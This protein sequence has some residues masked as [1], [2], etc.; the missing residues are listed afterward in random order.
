MTRI[1]VVGAINEDWVASV[2]HRPGPG[3]TV[4]TD[5]FSLSPGGKGANQA[6]AAARAGASVAMIGA[7]GDDDSGRRQLQAL[8]AYGV[9]VR[10]VQKIIGVTTGTAF[11]TVTGDGENSIVVGLG[12]NGFL[13]P[14]VPSGLP[15]P[16]VVLAQTEVG[17]DVVN[18]AAT[19]A[20]EV[21]ARLVVN[22]G[23]VVPLSPATLRSA[24]PIVVN[25]HEAA[26]IL[27][28]PADPAEIAARIRKHTSA[29]SAV[30]TL[31]AD[32]A[33]FSDASG[34]T[35][36][37]GVQA[38]QVVDTTGA[39]D[40]FVGVLGARLAA[41]DGVRVAVRAAVAAA[42]ESVSWRGARPPRD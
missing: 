25:A 3:Q 14:G 34:E 8:S 17:P 35:A 31:G 42:A 11:I 29:R 27:G 18:A 21:G 13:A 19:Y 20:A 1:V 2:R 30:V 24:D 37:A 33:V 4:V 41:G 32:G 5:R 38:S 22:N 16:A 40:T 39:G 9:D 10:G 12:A 26:D 28:S 23:P 7:V 6:V 36:V 15:D